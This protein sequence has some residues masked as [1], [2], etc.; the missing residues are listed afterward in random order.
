MCVWRVGW[1]SY[2]SA[3]FMLTQIQASDCKSF[4]IQ[5]NA[6]P[7]CRTA[8]LYNNIM[9]SPTDA[10]RVCSYSAPIL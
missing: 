2:I 1:T 7:S 3:D 9:L 4:Q 6:N 10:G 8:C 5:P